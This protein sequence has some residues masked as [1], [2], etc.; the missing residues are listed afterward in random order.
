MTI[1]ELIQGLIRQEKIEEEEGGI[2]YVDNFLFAVTNQKRPVHMT[3]IL[4]ELGR[5]VV[6]SS[7]SIIGEDTGEV[8]TNLVVLVGLFTYFYIRKKLN[9][10]KKVGKNYFNTNFFQSY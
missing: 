2:R 4:F 8:L 3:K 5:N 7:F 9:E 1:K 6:A 10:E